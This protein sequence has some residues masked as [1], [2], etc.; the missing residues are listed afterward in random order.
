MRF[1]DPEPVIAQVLQP[2]VG[3][4]PKIL[5]PP[6]NTKRLQAL[7][8]P[9]AIW[10][11]ESNFTGQ[12]PSGRTINQHGITV[13]FWYPIIQGN[14]EKA[15]AAVKRLY[16]ALKRSSVVLV[17]FNMQTDNFQERG[18]SVAAGGEAGAIIRSVVFV[19]RI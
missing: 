13:E 12:N 6:I 2:D 15:D 11:T 18:V 3:G 1:L 17:E 5:R 8:D 19:V 16:R 10:F 4:T 7:K 9:V 14:H